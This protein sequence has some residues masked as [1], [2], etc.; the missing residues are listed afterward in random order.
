MK[1]HY[2]PEYES[3]ADNSG[4]L[5][6][7]WLLKKAYTYGISK[8]RKIVTRSKKTG[9]I[10]DVGCATGSFLLGMKEIHS[11]EVFGVEI[12][13]HA[14]NIARMNGLEVFTGT[15]EEANFSAASFDAVTLWDVL[16]HL[17]DPISSLGEIYRILKPEGTLVVRVPNGAS[18]DAR[19][20]GKTWA[21]WD[22]PRHLYVF[23]IS[24]LETILKANGFRISQMSCEIGG[25][26]TF[27]LSVRFWLYHRNIS[28]KTRKKITRWL[29]HPISRVLS[30]PLFYILGLR[31][32]GPLLTVTATKAG[33]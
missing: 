19:W 29:Y 18:R 24:T 26:P 33:E 27:V 32:R 25:Y 8:R 31:L 20:F 15:L 30:A 10:L 1:Q 12:S 4:N 11:W 17:H 7:P 6:L 13:P 14:A 3:Y 16:E 23:T 5:D 21:G 2:P 9:R 22:A 28:L